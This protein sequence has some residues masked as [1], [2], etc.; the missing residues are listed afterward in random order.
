M[1][2][3]VVTTPAAGG[4]SGRHVD[5]R[6]EIARTGVRQGDIADAVGVSEGHLSHL[7]AGRKTLTDEMADKIAAAIAEAVAL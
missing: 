3:K 6:V 1:G 7:L 4:A 2:Q 5:L